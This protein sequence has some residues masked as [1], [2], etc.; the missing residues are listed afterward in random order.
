MECVEELKDLDLSRCA[1]ACVVLEVRCLG[2]RG[3][4]R[5]DDSGSNLARK[6]TVGCWMV[7]EPIGK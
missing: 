1:W 2:E 6:P 7:L 4:S 3:F 5:L